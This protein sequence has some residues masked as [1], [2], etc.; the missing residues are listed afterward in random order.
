MINFTL[1]AWW[2]NNI[3]FESKFVSQS[4]T[5]VMEQKNFFDFESIGEVQQLSSDPNQK[6]STSVTA[7]VPVAA[8]I[9]ASRLTSHLSNFTSRPHWWTN[10]EC[11]RTIWLFHHYLAGFVFSIFSVAWAPP[12][13]VL[14]NISPILSS[15]TNLQHIA[16]NSGREQCMSF[17][18]LV[19]FSINCAMVVL[20]VFVQFFLLCWV[21]SP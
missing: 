13:R 15:C 12:P 4:F 3:H 21:I 1:K 7:V 10:Q 8:L 18:V 5:I 14:A 2:K 16:S 20:L 17:C 9:S 6:W 11:T 19:C